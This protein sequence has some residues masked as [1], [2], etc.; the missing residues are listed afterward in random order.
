MK[1][2]IDFITNINICYL[3]LNGLLLLSV[4]L[5]LKQKKID[6]VKR[7]ILLFCTFIVSILLFFYFN[8][9]FQNVFTLKYLSVKSYLLVLAVT[10]IITLVTINKRIRIGYAILN[11]TLFILMMLVFIVVFIVM[12]GNKFPQFY[13]MG[14]QNVVTLIDL[15]FVIFILYLIGIMIVYIGYYVFASYQI[16]DLKNLLFIIK[17]SIV[18]KKKKKKALSFWKHKNINKDK[19][20]KK[21]II[22][23]PEELLGYEDKNNFYIN[24]VECSIIFEDSNQGNI[25][26]NYYI[27][28]ED[29]HAKMVN[30]FTLDE[31]KLLKSIC[32][33]LEVVN[34]E[35]IDIHNVNILNRVSI[36]EYNFLKRIM[37][38]Y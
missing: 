31:N 38:F 21:V 2:V 11:Y 14:I 7:R 12:L 27:L 36:E 32:T 6:H 9:V 3:V 16:H 24:G 28:V 10:N 23:T 25:V 1:Q 34:L 17:T 26:K 29:I 13:L 22:L 5:Y 15:S 30:G 18:P 4:S 20:K 35:N 37:E 8:G 33:K 19:E